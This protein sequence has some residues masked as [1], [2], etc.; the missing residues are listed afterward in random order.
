MIGQDSPELRSA[1]FRLLVIPIAIY[2]AWVIEIF[3]LEGSVHLFSR[4]NPPGLFPYTIIGCIITG[5]AVPLLCIRTAFI[6]GAVNMFQIGFRS[7]RRTFIACLI[8]GSI[9][10]GAII[11]FN[12]SGTDL[13]AFAN[14]F[15][16]LL[17]SVI[18]SVMICW[19][20][21]GTYVQAFVRSGGAFIS[22]SVG[23]MVTTVLYSLTTFAY[24]PAILQQEALFSS[25]CL[26]IIAAV[27][28]F[29]V[30]DVYA[31]SLIAGLCS[32][33]TTSEH[34]SPLYLHEIVPAVWISAA[35]SF[36]ALM[37]IHVYLSRNYVTLKIPAK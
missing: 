4:F 16:L 6:S 15:L 9:G 23:I 32:V 34:I 7:I 33:F 28:F 5:M 17:P 19:V 12:P 18:A 26:G 14:A 35:L 10:Y 3:L 30:R 1:T 11:L 13:F 36:G 24:F 31:T 2:S 37:S 22:L 27:F 8:T 21:L 25:A 29:A 20:L